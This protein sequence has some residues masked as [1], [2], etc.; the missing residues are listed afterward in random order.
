M[1]SKKPAA[2]ENPS[3]AH[4]IFPV[5][6][7]LF[8]LITI[9]KFGSPIIIDRNGVIEVPQN[10]ASLLYEMWPPHW[11]AWLFVPVGLAGLFAVVVDRVKLHWALMLPLVWLAWEFVSATQTVSTALTKLTLTQFTVCVSLFYLGFFARKGMSNPW[12]V[13]AGMGLALC[14]VMRVGMEQHFGGLEATRKM[15]AASPEIAGVNAKMLTDPEY[16]KRLAS[17]RIFG[18]FGGYSNSLAGGIVLLLP[19]T[20]VFLWRLTPKVRNS[21]RVL[22]VLILG[23]CG[24]GCLY[25]SGS[26]AGWLVALVMG[27][28]ALGHSA[29]PLKWKRW[30]IGGVLIVGVAGFALKYASFF[31]KERNSVGARFVYWRAALFVTLHH[32]WLGTG[33][34][35]FQIPFAKIKSP[36]DEMARLCHN[37]YLEQA[38]DSG[39][40]GFISYTAMILAFVLLLYRYS[41][42]D[43]PLN[44]LHFAVWLGIIGLCLHSLVEFHLYVPALAWPM[45]FLCGWLMSRYSYR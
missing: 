29:L 42:Q 34:G 4:L 16:I 31:H 18:T 15:L 10:T 45:F 2:P 3:P 28:A 24:L 21:I 5:M 22:F 23:G 20:L 26:K 17:N 41:I 11:G 27:L 37:D 39:V 44:W 14:W 35:T 8:F 30:L 19:L 12:P 7:G 43:R 25:W 33:P 6:A 38:T 1:S 32:P 13:W 9:V 36:A 40:F